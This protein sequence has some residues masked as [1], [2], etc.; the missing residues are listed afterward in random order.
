MKVAR[1]TLLTLLVVL[2]AGPWF[3]WRPKVS[4]AQTDQGTQ[5][6]CDQSKVVAPRDIVFPYYS[7][8]DGFSS[9]L[10][11]VNASP[12]ALDLTV[13]IHSLSGQTVLAPAM[14]IQGL[15]S[16]SIDLGS[17]LTGL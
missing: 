17:V 7:L 1:V 6:C 12:Q 13:A 15:G 8:R 3:Y 16:L 9:T 4:R 2:I 14:T 10:Y 11:L 5:P